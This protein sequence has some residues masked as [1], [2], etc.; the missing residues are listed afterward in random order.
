[1]SN[2][3]GTEARV[4]F[5]GGAELAVDDRLHR[6]LFAVDRDDQNVL[7]R[8]LAG[9]LDRGDRAERHFVVVGVDDRRVGMGLEQRLGDL[10]SLVAVEV[11]GLAG[12]DGHLGRLG[13]DR[14]VEALL[15]IIGRRS[16]DG[17]FQLDDLALAAGLVDRPVGDPLAFL[18][19][20]R[21]D[22]GEIVLARLGERRIEMRSTSSTGMPAFLAAR[23]AGS[24]GFSSRGARK[25]KSTPWAI[26]QLTSATCLAAESA[27]SV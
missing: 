1:M 9:G 20:V 13:L 15:A 3:A 12:D 26:M 5:A 27:A 24:S 16:A 4:A 6:V 17:A 7:A 25:M 11:A 21:A 2:E 10:P 14:L 23:T 22:E 18:D 8:N 19:E